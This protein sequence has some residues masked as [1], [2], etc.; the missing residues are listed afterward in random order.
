MKNDSKKIEPLV[1]LKN[2]LSGYLNLGITEVEYEISKEE[3]LSSLKNDVLICHKCPLYKTKTQYVFGEGAPDSSL[4]FIGEA[5]GYYEDAKGRVFIGKAGQLLTKIIEAM[6]FS[7]EDVYI[8]N[9]LKCRP[10]DNRNPMGNEIKNCFPYLARQIEIIKPEVICALGTFAAQKL[11]E[12]NIPI[13]KI[14][15]KLFYYND[16]KVVP[17][18]HPSFLL[19]NSNYK[20]QTW[21]DAKFILRLLGREIDKNK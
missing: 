4:M 7:R 6:G 2:T 5:P 1:A 19:R 17:T 15:G 12:T 10:P 21:E 16:I 9:I 14:R 8:A 3:A 11:I 20:R 18:F 13:S